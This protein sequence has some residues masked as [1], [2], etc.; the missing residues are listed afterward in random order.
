MLMDNG[1]KQSLLNPS[2]KYIFFKL[3]HYD[4]Y[5]KIK[6]SLFNKEGKSQVELCGVSVFKLKTE[7]GK[8]RNG[9]G[10]GLSLCGTISTA[11]C[12]TAADAARGS[13]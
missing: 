13:C 10:R 1:K 3:S 8:L 9:V 12:E 7:N 4:F 5:I 11:I 2:L 6:I